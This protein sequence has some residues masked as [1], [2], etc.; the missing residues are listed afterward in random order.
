MSHLA[1]FDLPLPNDTSRK[2]IHVD[3]DAFYASIEER[4]HP[5][6]KSKALVIA[7]DPRQTGSKGVITTANYIARQYGVNSAMPS[8]Q[9]LKLIPK[10][11]LVF[12]DPDFTK[13]RAVSAQIHTIFHQVTDLVE[14]VAFDE[15]Y[16]DVTANHHFSSTIQ[17]ALWLQQQIS[18]QTHLTSSIGISY[19]KFLAKQASDYNKPAG[20]TV[21][22]P[23]QA[24]L[25]LDQLPIGQFRGVGKKTLPKLTDLG[26]TDGKTLR[27]LNQQTLIDLFGKMGFLLYQHARGVDNRPVAVRDAKSIGKERTYGAVLTTE[28]QVQNQLQFLANLVATALQKGQKHGKTVV[29]KVRDRDFETHTKRVTMDHYIQDEA[30]ILAAAQEL[31]QQEKPSELLI[32]LLGITVTNLD[33]IQYENIDLNLNQ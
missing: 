13:Y 18:A 21:V 24:L 2:I 31:W 23:E 9:A 30:T 12:K 26:V 17:L 1:L 22:M 8:N 27:Q 20:R 19:N 32:R 7:H 11:L 10:Q 4:D 29:L 15:A 16:L 5:A 6:Y 3:M 14:P 33:P 28:E 25:F